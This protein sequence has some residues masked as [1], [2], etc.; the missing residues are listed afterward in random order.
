MTRGSN[1]LQGEIYLIVDVHLHLHPQN[2]NN[3]NNKY[4]CKS[5]S[6][7]IQS[8]HLKLFNGVDSLGGRVLLS[9]ENLGLVRP[10]LHHR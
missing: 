5:K 7:K 8:A 10:A 2:M 9:L 6:S 1:A 3:M 4:V